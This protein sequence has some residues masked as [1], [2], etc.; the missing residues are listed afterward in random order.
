MKLRIGL[1][2]KHGRAIPN[3]VRKIKEANAKR[4]AVNLATNK[5]TGTQEELGWITFWAA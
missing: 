4:L 5:S 3:T 2:R 1:G